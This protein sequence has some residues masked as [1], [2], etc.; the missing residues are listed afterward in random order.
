MKRAGKAHWLTL[1][2][3]VSIFIVIGLFLFAKD[4]VAE[5]TGGFMNALAR[6]DVGRLVELSY[7]PEINQDQ[8]KK[9]W[10]FTVNRAGPHYRFSYRIVN[11]T[12]SD[13]STAAA[14]LMVIRNV[15]SGSSYE[16]KFQLPLVKDRDQWKVDIRAISRTLYPG[17]PR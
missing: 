4:D 8:L 12:H 17:L 10:D 14:T 5:T 11:I 16:E 9:K 3:I 7:Y 15:D 13:P 6:G 2:G 1:A